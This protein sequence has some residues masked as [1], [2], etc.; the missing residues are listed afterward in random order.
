V[1]VE[2]RLPAALA[3][4]DD[5]AVVLEPFAT[6]GVGDEIQHLL[7]LVRGELRDLTEARDVPLGDHEQVDVGARVDVADRDEAVGRRD[8]IAL[9]VE[10]AEEA[11]VRQR[12]S[13]PP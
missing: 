1:E 11:V 13:P 6:R 10:L 9:A 2:D 4:V 5:D 12:G 7:G 3:D 8:V